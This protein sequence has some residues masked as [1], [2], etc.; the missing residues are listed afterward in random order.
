MAHEY[1]H[2]SNGNYET[3]SSKLADKNGKSELNLK[4]NPVIYSPACSCLQQECS[5][6]ALKRRL[7]HAAGAYP[8]FLSMKRLGVFLLPLDGMLVHRRSLPRNLLGFPN[9]SAVPIYISRWREAMWELSD[10]ALPK[11]TTQCPQPGLEP[12]PL[13]L[14]TNALTIASTRV[15]LLE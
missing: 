12:R 11:N 14:G 9:N 15:F 4:G 8:G 10:C 2:F 5:C 1:A 3:R 13:A 7:A 6:E